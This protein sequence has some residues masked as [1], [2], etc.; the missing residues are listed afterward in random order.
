MLKSKVFP[1]KCTYL[2]RRDG[3]MM[4]KNNKIDHKNK[5]SP[6]I[7][8]IQPAYAHYR[9]GLFNK[10][11][12]NFDILFIFLKGTSSYPSSD[13]PDVNWHSMCLHSETNLYWVITLLKILLTSKYDIVISSN[14]GNTQ[15]TISLFIV[16]L[17]NKS[18]II[19]NLKWHDEFKFSNRILL[20]KMFRR[21][22]ARYIRK[23]SDSIVVSGSAALKYHIRIGIPEYKIFVAN[24][25]VENVSVNIKK[26]IPKENLTINKKYVILY[27]SRIIS[28]KG[29]DILIKAFK[30]LE[31]KGYDVFLLI[32]GDG[33]F[34]SY[35]EILSN[36]IEVENIKFVGS[37]PNEK[38]YYYYHL[39]DI[40][41]LPTCQRGNAEAWGL[42]I[43]EAMSAGKPVVTTDAVG[44]ADDLVKNGINGYVV[45]NNN[46][47][48]MYVALKKIID[49]GDSLIGK[50]GNNSL[51]IFNE[52]NDYNKMFLGFKKAIEYACMTKK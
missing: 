20:Y 6:K 50:M 45:P 48:E 2:H 28:W 22:H 49:G 30:R 52:F 1:Q 51:R 33:P 25:S 32:G 13:K 14:P 7:I 5:N 29:L 3:E 37:I 35:C 15:S 44:A 26:T 36:N 38:V 16:K 10:L 19:W 11:H 41:V 42:V 43:N 24:Q 17:L 39:S 4:S 40:F 23:K 27:L 47:E 46:I 34:K 8:F 18:H 12:E 9:K 21:T 31:K